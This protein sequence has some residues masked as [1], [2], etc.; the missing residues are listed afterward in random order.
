MAD[1]SRLVAEAGVTMTEIVESVRRVTDIMAEISAASQEQTAGIEQINGAVAQ[2]DEG[3]QQNAALVEEAA[4]ASASMQEQAAKLAQA[5]AVFRIDGEQA[6]AA[7]GIAE[8][9]PARA[10]IATQARTAPRT[11][12]AR[13]AVQPPATRNKVPVTAGEWEEF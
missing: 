2:M 1:G 12:P 5:V 10:R 13:P 11:A 7:A 6:R 3:T 8:P 4:A 9:P